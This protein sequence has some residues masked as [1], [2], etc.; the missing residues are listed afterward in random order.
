MT[1][2][3][4]KLIAGGMAV[5]ALG[6]VINGCGDSGPTTSGK[7]RKG[8]I[9]DWPNFL[10]PLLDLRNRK[11][12]R[13]E[14]RD[15]A[16]NPHHGLTLLPAPAHHVVHPIRGF[17]GSFGGDPGMNGKPSAP[18]PGVGAIDMQ[19]RLFREQWIRGDARRLAACRP[20]VFA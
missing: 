4:T 1:E 11:W 3:R 19:H 8:A 9:Q 16:G 10:P 5:L 15:V 13:F 17:S 14:I 6:T 7:E 2:L 12:V 20:P 18:A